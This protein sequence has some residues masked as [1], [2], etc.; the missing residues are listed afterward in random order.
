M[1]TIKK[2]NEFSLM[3]N[4]GAKIY[5]KYAIIFILKSQKQRFGFVTSKKIGNAVKRNRIRRIFRSIIRIDIE[6]FKKDY[7]YV[8][9]AKKNCQDDFKLLNYA[10]LKEDILQGIKKHEKNVYRNNR[11]LSKDI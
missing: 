2:T 11:N 6:K 3:Y 4:K 1:E 7:S 5:T 8:F 10:V 9:V